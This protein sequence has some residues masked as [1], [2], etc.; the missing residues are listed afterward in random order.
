M[1]K[2]C[3]NITWQVFFY[4]HN[5]IYGT[6]SPVNPVSWSLEIEIQ[7]YLLVPLLVLIFLARHSSIRILLLFATVIFFI[8]LPSVFDFREYNLGFSIFT[9]G[10][11]FILG[12]LLTEFYLQG[13]L[14][15]KFR[16]WDLIVFLSIALII[17]LKTDQV[18]L[19]SR[20]YNSMALSF[21]LSLFFIGGFK[22]LVANKILNHRIVTTIGGMCYTL[23]LL[24]FPVY[25]I[26]T[27]AFADLYFENYLLIY[28]I[29][30]LT[31]FPISII[32]LS[33]IY[34]ILEKPFMYR[35]W[36]FNNLKSI[37]SKLLFNP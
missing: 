4:L 18:N 28:L 30:L 16:I 2:I 24:H 37:Y 29:L 26:L 3:L 11:F 9:Y 15:Q 8:Y 33:L 13:L 10:H 22:G 6:I 35:E 32:S 17:A 21:L 25:F 20:L 34:L 7:F 36:N 31:I 12:F 27:K 14:Q 1:S 19:G 5:I 23:Y